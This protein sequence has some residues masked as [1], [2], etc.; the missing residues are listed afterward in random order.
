MIREITGVG[1][2][3]FIAIGEGFAGVNTWNGFL[4]NSDRIALDYHPY[5]AFTGQA[6]TQPIST[7]TGDDAGGP[8]PK[9]ACEA[10]GPAISQ[11]YVASL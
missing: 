11:A 7:G 2:G 9:M 8:W 4:P 1:Q 6:N 3:P 5:F 10:W